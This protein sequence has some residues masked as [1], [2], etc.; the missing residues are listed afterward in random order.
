MDKLR[1]ALGMLVLTA[2]LVAGPQLAA[3]AS[4][5]HLPADK[6]GV[7]GATLDVMTAP[8]NAGSH[9]E[10]Q[11]L[12]N[13]TLR[14]SSPTD[15]II[16]VTAECALWTSVTN[17][18]PDSTSE[19]TATVKLWVELDGSPVKVASSDASDDNGQVVFCNRDYKVVMQHFDQNETLQQ[20]LNTRTANAFNWVALNVGNG[21]HTLEVKGQL[22]VQVSGMGTAQA[23]VG[24]RTLIVDPVKLSNDASI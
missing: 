17:V 8:L 5:T 11:S 15:L 12:L 13:G 23:A 14:A 2:G 16:S 24:K 4:G 22:D 20:F 3:M 21:V 9:S 19:S 18:G 6:I 10:V 7:A 1:V